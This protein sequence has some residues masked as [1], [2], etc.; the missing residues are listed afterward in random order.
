MREAA[1]KKK[2]ETKMFVFSC[3]FGFLL[4]L[5]LVSILK[6]EPELRFRLCRDVFYLKE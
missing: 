3:F 1:V 5:L 6:A 4:I 2:Q